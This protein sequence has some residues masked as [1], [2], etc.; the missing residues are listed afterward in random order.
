MIDY[1]NIDFKNSPF[2]KLYREEQLKKIGKELKRQKRKEN[3]EVAKVAFVFC[4]LMFS[5][6]LD[7]EFWRFIFNN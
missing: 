2:L 4:G 3:W 5:T 6:Y 7:P 1:N